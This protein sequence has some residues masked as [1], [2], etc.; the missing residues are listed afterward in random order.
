[1]LQAHS[2][3]V[4]PKLDAFATSALSV[5]QDLES[6]QASSPLSDGFRRLSSPADSQTIKVLLV[7]LSP[8]S[9]SSALSQLLNEDF[10]ICRV[11]VPS[12]LGY[13]EVHL[14]ER[15]FCLETG[16]DRQEFDNLDTFVE[17]LR[18]EDLVQ[19]GNPN[20]WMDPLRL[21]LKAP[22]SMHGLCLLI[23]DS[24]SSLQKKPA[25]LSTLADQSDWVLLAGSKNEGIDPRQKSTLQL[26]LDQ[27]VGLQCLEVPSKGD[28]ERDPSDEASTP[29]WTDWKVTLSLGLVSI[30]SAEA[31]RR[32]EMLT[33]STSELRRWVL[34]NRRHLTI[35][36][37]LELLDNSIEQL[38]TQLKNRRKLQDE[39]LLDGSGMSSGVSRPQDG[40]QQ[41]LRD[42]FDSLRRSLE[43]SAKRCLLP[44]SAINAQIDELIN[45]IR[46]SD[47]E[48][49]ETQTLIKL[50]LADDALHRCRAYLRK[51]GKEQFREDLSLVQD[52]LDTT[53]KSVSK[54]LSDQIKFTRK[55]SYALPDFESLWRG[56]EA[57]VSP[58]IRYRGEMPVPTLGSRF[59]AARQVT[60]PLMIGGMMIGGAAT[61]MGGQGNSV[62]PLLYAIM[63]PMFIIGFF[64]TYVSFRKKEELLLEK[65]VE[66]LRDGI[67]SELKR[68]LNELFREE[69]TTL[70]QELSKISR[71]LESQMQEA[72]DRTEQRS[73]GEQESLRQKA[74]QNVRSI[75]QKISNW[76]SKRRELKNLQ[77]KKDQI[78]KSLTLWLGDWINH[79]NNGTL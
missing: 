10:N 13:T 56:I 32:L 49:T 70:N 74:S 43:D 50:G 69:R 16:Q 61:F 8:E 52:T 68:N 31:Q 5:A 39:G 73:K 9:T 27:V 3:K 44:G 60:M 2:S 71:D 55:L 53:S 21:Q 33:S 28:A 47:I 22:T 40:L 24:L 59:S 62:R 77:L 18:K 65:E 11:V 7:G 26:I 63:L 75:E 37:H 30:E 20:S 1:M 38:L 29:W 6:G 34:E 79:F 36:N 25:L 4:S 15:G 14:Q 51:I 19:D 58:E 45:S 67:Q 64:Y 76:T 48:Q 42:D 23:P 57:I 12:R 17:A 54:K 66:K 72:I 46:E 78:E 35:N 41:L